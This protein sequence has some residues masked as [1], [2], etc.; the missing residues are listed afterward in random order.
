LGEAAAQSAL[1]P[2]AEAVLIYDAYQATLNRHQWYDAEGE[3][4]L[5]RSLLTAPQGEEL[6]SF[7]AIVVDGFSDFTKTQH[8]ILEQLTQR[9]QQLSISL[10]CDVSTPS[11]LPIRKDL[12][13]KTLATLK[14]LRTRH[15][16]VKV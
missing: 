5:A 16:K 3:F 9:T 2:Q 10:L 6:P 1:A 8:E 4:W 12:F 14:E 15:E 13:A 7:D 11:N